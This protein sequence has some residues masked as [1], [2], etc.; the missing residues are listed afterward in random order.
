MSSVNSTMMFS[1]FQSDKLSFT[2]LE[3]NQRSKGQRI[4][5]PRYEAL[6]GPLLIQC[7]WFHI[8]C[9]GVPSVCEYYPDDSKRDFIKVPLNQDIPEVKQLTETLQALDQ[10][11]GSNA[12][13]E[14]LLGDKASKYE[15]QPIIR[16]QDE[17]PQKKD[18][19]YPRPSYPFYMK[20]KLDTTYPD[21]KVKT[22]VFL[23]EPKEVNGKQTRERTKTEINTIDEMAKQVWLSKIRPI[24]RPVKL[25]AQPANK[26][27]ASYG[28]TFKVVRLEVEPKKGS[29]NNL[30]K[31][32]EA[33]TFLDSDDETE[34]VSKS[35]SKKAAPVEDSDEES[36]DEPAPVKTTTKSAAKTPVKTVQVD[37]DE[38]SDDEPVVPVK[39]KASVKKVE[40]DDSDDE[41]K[42]TKSKSKF[43]VS[44]TKKATV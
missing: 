39:S 5:Y 44:K 23:S 40:S 8:D 3:E 17:A 36:E 30:Q 24:V 15:Y 29:G 20:L 41:P 14:K 18:S 27:G 43:T 22:L 25:W 6:D 9:M 37:S 35:V 4:A 13:R 32:M 38:E 7:P 19:K 2:E 42:V 12:M 31:Y 16:A 26:K 28:V 10:R 21:Y 33:D 11:L 1:N 34:P